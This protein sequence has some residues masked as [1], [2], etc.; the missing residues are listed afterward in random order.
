[1]VQDIFPG[2][3]LENSVPR[4]CWVSKISGSQSLIDHKKRMPK[5]K[6]LH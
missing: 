5:A 1:M 6:K 4:K 3:C 2:N